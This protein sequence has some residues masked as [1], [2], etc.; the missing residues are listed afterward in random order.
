MIRKLIP[1][2]LALLAFLGGAAAG[3]MLKGGG[4]EEAAHGE[5]ADAGHGGSEAETAQDGHVEPAESDAAHAAPAKDAAAS[6][7]SDGHGK[8]ESDHGAGGHGGAA[9]DPDAAAWFKFPQQFF[10]PVLHGGQLDSTMVLSLSVEMPGAATEKVYAHEIKLRDALLRQLLIQA[11]TGAFDGNF[12]SEPQLRKMRTAL[13]GAAQEVVP[14][15]TD[16]LV[17]D[18]ARQER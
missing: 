2:I 16:I 9:A 11:N 1:V 4:T 17:G 14:E 7:S 6:S 13:V 10:I 3:D 8:A 12:T 5:A 18:I 15:I